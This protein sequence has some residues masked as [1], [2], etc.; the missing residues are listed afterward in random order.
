L[1]RLGE[2]LHF[3]TSKHLVI[4]AKSLPRL[5]TIAY[6]ENLQKIGIV[7]EIFGP[8]KQPYISVKP[9]VS[10]PN[11]YVGKILYSL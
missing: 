10:K 11:S 5:G 6:D 2:V 4:R 9:S 1:F 7:V 8:V 3:S